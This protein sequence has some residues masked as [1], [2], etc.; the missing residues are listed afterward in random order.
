R[1]SAGHV[2]RLVADRSDR[3]HV[4]LAA[5]KPRRGQTDHASACLRR[6]PRHAGLWFCLTPQIFLCRPKSLHLVD[7]AVMTPAYGTNC[8]LGHPRTT[9]AKRQ[10]IETQTAPRLFSVCLGFRTAG[11]TARLC[12]VAGWDVWRR[13]A[14][15]S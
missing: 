11:C 5:E 12:A 6:F 9:E 3:R 13:A 4:A 14:R 1:P 15:P 7:I 2:E 8:Q 10:L